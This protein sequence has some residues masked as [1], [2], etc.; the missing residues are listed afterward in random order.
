M[1]NYNIIVNYKNSSSDDQY[2]I[3]FCDVFTMP[4]Y[5]NDIVL[6][7]INEVFSKYKDNDDFKK[8]I[9]F[10]QR[11]FNEDELHSFMFLFS[12]DSFEILHKCLIDLN[13]HQQI[14]AENM[15]LLLQ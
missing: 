2:R 10:A 6:K 13:N 14:T 4:Q 1:Y 11:K 9:E 3:C 8:I 15:Q 5:D 7:T 12:W